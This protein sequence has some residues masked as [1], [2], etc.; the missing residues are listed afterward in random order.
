[1]EYSIIG[2][3]HFALTK[4]Y[5][6]FADRTEDT[7]PVGANRDR[8]ALE[9]GSAHKFSPW[10]NSG[11]L[12]IRYYFFSWLKELTEYQEPEFKEECLRFDFFRFWLMRHDGDLG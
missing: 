9:F 12:S 3:E 4:L 6:L 5:H 7:D 11:C 1:V 8:D 2:G 10:I